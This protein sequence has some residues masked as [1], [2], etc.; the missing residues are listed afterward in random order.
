MIAK[1]LEEG[2]P[3]LQRRLEPIALI[4]HERTS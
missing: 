1:V 3:S 2:I 4:G